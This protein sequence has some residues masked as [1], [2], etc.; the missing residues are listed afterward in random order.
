MLIKKVHVR[1]IIKKL[2]ESGWGGEIRTPECQ[3]Q[4]LVPYHLATPHRPSVRACLA[5]AS[6]QK[7]RLG[8]CGRAL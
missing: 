2:P 6:R 7:H 4:N 1:T 8:C 5:L 3:D